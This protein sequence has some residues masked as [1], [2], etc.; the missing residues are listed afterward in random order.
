M[1]YCIFLMSAV[2]RF[3]ETMP[4]ADRGQFRANLTLLE[5]ADF[6]LPYTKKL[7]GIIRELIVGNY[8]FIFFI[9][10]SSVYFTSAFKKKSTKTPRR[11]IERAEKYYKL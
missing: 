6:Q 3:L 5:H 11:E 2:E 8:S 7:K 1:S 9:K 4:P 10:D